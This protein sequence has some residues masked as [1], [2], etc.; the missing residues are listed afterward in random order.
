MSASPLVL[1]KKVTTCTV[2]S[3]RYNSLFDKARDVCGTADDGS[4][5]AEP[6]KSFSLALAAF[7]PFLS[8]LAVGNHSGGFRLGYKG[9]LGGRSRP[10]AFTAAFSDASGCDHAGDELDLFWAVGRAARGFLQSRSL[11]SA[12]LPLVVPFDGEG[13]TP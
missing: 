10:G 7:T 9:G 4:V 1:D 5:G 12:S 11:G 8:P 3:L 13:R 6:D 2:D